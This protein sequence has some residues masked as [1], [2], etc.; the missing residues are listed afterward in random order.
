MAD[1][2]QLALFRA[3]A[4]P[5]FGAVLDA[6]PELARLE[7]EKNRPADEF[8]A[9]LTV[10]RGVYSVEELV[11]QPLTPALWSLLWCLGN[12]YT[13][14]GERRPDEL[15]TDLFLYCL[16]HGLNGL[17]ATPAE[18]LEAASGF[19]RQ[20][21]VDPA[22]AGADLQAIIHIALRPLEWLPPASGP[23]G[24]T[25][26]DADWLTA[27]AVT[28]AEL[29]HHP[30]DSIIREMPLTSCMY[31]YVQGRRR[32]ARPGEIGGRRTPDQLAEAIFRRTLE[33][34][35]AFVAEGGHGA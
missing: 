4:T 27:L 12:A 25:R 14:P 1:P 10:L 23:A 19:C 16:H 30:A 31:Y 28:V 9:L 17:P 6:D 3:M 33:L 18:L 11:V 20:R 21:G 22:V 5:A 24:E 26:Y 8:F 7:R 15:D 32:H 35:R 34:G 2:E 29:T 13:R